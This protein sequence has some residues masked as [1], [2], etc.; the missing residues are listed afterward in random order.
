MYAGTGEAAGTWGFAGVGLLKS[1]DGGATWQLVSNKFAD[2][3]FSSIKVD[4]GNPDNLLVSTTWGRAPYCP[5]CPVS[6]TDSRPTGVFKSVDGGET[7]DLK[8]PGIASDLVVNPYQFTDAYAGIGSQFGHSLNGVYRS[9]DGAVSWN[10]IDGPWN[11]KSGGV[12]RIQLAL[13]TS[14]PNVLYVL[15]G[16]AQDGKGNDNQILGIWRTENAW[17][18]DPDWQELP[19]P[20]NNALSFGFPVDQTHLALTVDPN[21][22]DVLFAG[23]IRL[24]RWKRGTS[25]AWSDQTSQINVHFTDLIH[26]DF[27]AMAWAGNRL[28]VGNDG[29]VYST[30]DQ[31][32]NWFNHNNG[33]SITQFYSGS[34]HPTNPD[35]V[36]AGSQDNGTSIS[37]GI[38]D[39]RLILGGD[40]GDNAFS[41]RPNTHWAVSTQDTIY[42]TTDAG[43]SFQGWSGT[44]MG[45]V[46]VRIDTANFAMCPANDNVVIVSATHTDM[47]TKQSTKHIWKTENFFSSA[48]KQPD[49][50]ENNTP[51]INEKPGIGTGLSA[52]AFAA[53]D[54]SCRTYAFGTTTS[55]IYLT[56]DGGS[57]WRSLI[58][59]DAIPCC[60]ED[61]AFHPSD[62]NIL[63]V[64]AAPFPGWSVIKTTNALAVFPSW[65][66][67]T[68]TDMTTA[69]ASIVLDPL[70][71]NNIYV[72]TM[73]DMWHSS[74]DGNTWK[75]MGPDVGLPHVPVFDLKA[76]AIGDIFAFTYGRGAYVFHPLNNEILN[77]D[78]EVGNTN[79]VSAYTY[80]PT[81][82]LAARTYGVAANPQ[83]IHPLFSSCG[84]HT[85]GAGNMM[86]VN[87]AEQVGTV[88]WSQTVA[89]SR[90]QTYDFSAWATSVYPDSPA[91]LRFSINGSYVGELQLSTETCQWQAFKIAWSSGVSTTATLSI[92][93]LNTAPF[94]NDFALDDLS[95]IV[96]TPSS[97][98]NGDFESGNSNF[99]SSYTY[100]PGDLSADRTYT[101]DINPQASQPLFSSCGDHTTGSGNMMVVNGA[102]NPNVVI[103]SQTVAVSP[104]QT[105][106]FSVWA[107]SV[108]VTSLSAPAQLQFL[109]NGSAVGE[110]QLLGDA[111]QWQPFTASW[112]SGVNT[113]ATLSIIDLNTAPF[114]NDFALDDV[115]F[116]VSD[117]KSVAPIARPLG[118]RP[119]TNRSL[120]PRTITPSRSRSGIQ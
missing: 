86:I 14:N 69:P 89:V 64:A 98:V 112:A 5:T 2:T 84:D 56:I 92:I 96:S 68:P 104:N 4:P 48:P 7:W 27:H 60:I 90:N 94:G 22:A 70:R 85:T 74:N 32:N 115:S 38:N 11:Q 21:D 25:P 20:N 6:P 117:P 106:D 101:V 44:T 1:F 17:A 34:A 51:P 71:P 50:F 31:G 43:V 87:G 42:R 28:I 58:D 12:G 119:L 13:G 30:P 82:L 45:N 75:Q 9:F 93:D 88:V 120:A 72:G 97:V 103:W 66:N 29:G 18:S 99:S 52:F 3:S 65:W 61:L 59:P 77:G 63:Y 57:V 105:Y 80:S 16:D 79:F 19:F 111:C 15:I 53:T 55:Q 73:R 95:L 40:G 10:K 78:F 110:L 83:G 46:S 76:N 100:S 116:G 49:W 67:I 41:S 35:V 39:W 47:T 91:H 62:A 81:D 118:T 26:V 108:F 8:L 33:L 54:P 102:Q 24:W 109:I 107:T 37:S 23:N 114:G 113:T 36:M